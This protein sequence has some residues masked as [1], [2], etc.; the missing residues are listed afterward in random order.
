MDSTPTP[1]KRDE[2]IAYIDANGNRIDLSAYKRRKKIVETGEE[3]LEQ[4]NR[5]RDR[6][7]IRNRWIIGIAIFLLLAIIG[8]C[9]SM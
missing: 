8:K 4:R 3:W 5:V 9:S 2:P 6:I 1:Q 7:R